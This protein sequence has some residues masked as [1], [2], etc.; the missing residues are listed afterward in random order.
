MA[1]QGS[2]KASSEDSVFDFGVR[3]I[4]GSGLSAA[5]Y[6]GQVL[7]SSDVGRIESAVWEGI[8]QAHRRA[9]A[10]ARFKG[11][12][13]DRFGALGASLADVDLAPVPVVQDIVPATYCIDPRRVPLSEVSRGGGGLQ[14]GPGRERP[15]RLCRRLDQLF[16]PP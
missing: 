10:N 7:G 16:H 2:E 5:G 1:E 9:R 14:G 3:V 13:R 4:A 8:R 11:R 6:C 12:A 15:H